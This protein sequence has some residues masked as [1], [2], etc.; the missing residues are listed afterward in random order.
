MKKFLSIT[1]ALTMALSLFAGCGN[2]QSSNPT[3]NNSQSA[4]NNEKDS[5]FTYVIHADIDD[6]NPYTSQAVQY[7]YFFTFNCFEPL[8]HLNADMEYEMD[9]AQSFEQVDDVTYTF[10]LREDV[11]F[12][13]GEKFTAQDV[14]H[15][16]NYV[17]DEANGSYKQTSFANVAEMTATD[18]Y[19]LT[20]KLSSPTPAFLDSLAWLAITSKST[21]VSSLTTKPIG[22]GAFRF[23]SWTP[24]D[25]IKLSKYEQ[26]W[27]ADNVHF[28][29]VTLKPYT[30]YTLAI[31]GLYAGDVDYISNMSIEQ[32]Q[33]VD[34]GKN[35]KVITAKSSNLT[36]LFEV[37][38][39]NVEAFQDANVMKAMKLVLDKAAINSSVYGGMGTA[40][41]SVF[42]SGAKYHKPTDTEGYDLEEAKRLMAESAYPDGFEFEVM[43]LS[44]DTN[45]EMACVIWQ[46][47]LAKLGITMKINMCESSIWLDAYLG[48]TYDMICNYYSMVGSDPATFC[49][50]I[51]APYA[52]HQCKDMPE[53][54]Q[55]IATGASSSDEAVRKAAY[56]QIQDMVSASSPVISYMEAPQVAA[57]ASNVEGV[58]MNGMAHVFLKGA[59]KN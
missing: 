7:A 32:A 16:I 13:N 5:E 42:P 2:T 58:T 26:Y 14:I 6:F 39:H 3:E 23:D 55:Q 35:A 15:T 51:L 48:R 54:F 40:A 17:K 36:Y 19:N 46:Q 38:L 29:K 50:I 21:D 53:L 52:D 4:V 9:L 24:N 22:T 20:I 12:H 49:T 56:A 43:V 37:G 28:D 1:L 33:A 44:G 10:K 34:T 30:D 8:F 18:D 25:S 31:N 59:S 47:E 11:T 41:T 57:A 27:D 45:S